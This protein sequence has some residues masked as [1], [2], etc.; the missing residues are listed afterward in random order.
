MIG[1]I[2][3]NSF[4]AKTGKDSV[5]QRLLVTRYDPARAAKDESL[6][7][8]D[9]EE[10]LG[11]PLIG[12]IPESKAILTSTNLGQ[13]VITSNDKA[14]EAYKD[15]VKRFLGQDI[16]LRFIEAEQPGF[17]ARIFGKND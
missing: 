5:V 11:L 8:K 15:V 6:N 4:R 9:I 3:S 13:P 10:L 17:F 2:A 16:P 7:L 12:V 1:F 14:G